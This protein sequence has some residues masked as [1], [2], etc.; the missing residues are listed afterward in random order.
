[1]SR[2]RATEPVEVDIGPCECPETPH[3]EGDKAWLR[4]RIRPDAAWAA[5]TLLTLGR[6]EE[7]MMRSLCPIFLGEVL[8]WNLLDDEGRPIPCTVE[9]MMD[10]SLDWEDTIKPIADEAADLYGP[11]VMR[12]LQKAMPAPSRNGRTAASTSVTPAS[13]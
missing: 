12:P 4:P 2:L 5:T 10:G 7:E 9:V 6:T 8:R 1:V 3:Q 11:Q 13:T